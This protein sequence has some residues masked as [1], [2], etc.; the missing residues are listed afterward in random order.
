MIPNSLNKTIA[1][2]DK[3][4]AATFDKAVYDEAGIFIVRNAVPQDIM[5]EWQ[6]EWET[7]YNASLAQGRD[8]HQANPVALKEQVPEKL[9]KIY[10]NEQLIN[11]MKQVHGDNVALYNHRFV[12][13]DKFSLDRVFL[14]QDCC[15]HLGNLNKCSFFLPLSYAGESNGGLSF[16]L[17]THKYGYLGDAGEINPEAFNVQW[18][19]VTPELN[20]GDLVIMNS[21]VWHESGPNVAKIDRIVV[22]MIVQ[23]ADD[24][25]G[26]ELICGEW[27]TD[28]WYPMEDPTKFFKSSRILKL[29]SK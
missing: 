23:P 4:D 27:E 15:Y 21:S 18:P 24:P 6:Q 5:Q 16:Y 20:P 11:I 7:F 12:I 22:D 19:K 3:I 29:R 8:V 28:I 1:V 25:T 14:H 26:K 17:G 9:A 2:Q 10:K 13:K